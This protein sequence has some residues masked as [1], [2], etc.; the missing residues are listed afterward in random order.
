[1]KRLFALIL[2]LVLVAGVPSLAFADYH[3]QTPTNQASADGSWMYWDDDVS[4]YGEYEPYTPPAPDPEPDEPTPVVKKTSP[5]T[6]ADLNLLALGSLG[7][8][9]AAGGIALALRKESRE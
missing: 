1:M 5:V 3:G 6:G 9:G 4:P 8:L 7:L 2:G